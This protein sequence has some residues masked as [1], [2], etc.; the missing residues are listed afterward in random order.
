[1]KNR[2]WFL[3]TAMAVLTSL[4]FGAETVHL[5]LSGSIQGV[6]QGDSTQTSLGRENSIECAG[7][8]HMVMGEPDPRN[9]ITGE[10]R[11]HFPL[12]ILKRLD[13]ATP[14]LFRAWQDRERLQAEF[15]FFR[16]NPSGDGT[17]QQFY[18]VILHNAYISGI[19]REVPNTFD[20]QTS[21]L[22]PV[23]RIS[24]TYEAIEEIW[25][26]T[27]VAAGDEW[28]ANTTK[29]PLSDVNFDGIVNMNDFVILADEWMMQY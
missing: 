13:K 4:S 15:W 18:K 19:R 24:F 20:P 6:I 17:T 3:L 14:R 27:G 23:E 9:G 16:P 29:I 12:T 26:P 22:P 2:N 5:F 1:M 8:T 10:V 11:D 21:T 28:H 25:M 7:Y